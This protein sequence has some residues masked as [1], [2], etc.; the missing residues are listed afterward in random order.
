MSEAH[1][2]I[3]ILGDY[4]LDVIDQNAIFHRE[5]WGDVIGADGNPNWP[6]LLALINEEL[7]ELSAAIMGKHEHP[8]ELELI[9]LGG[10][11]LNWLRCY[12]DEQI[13]SAQ[14]L[15]QAKHGD[16]NDG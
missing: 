13:L 9:Q 3:G 1:L 7:G 8:P 15:E 10:L 5:K 14:E 6:R 12:S 4:A 16:A 2:P 11:I